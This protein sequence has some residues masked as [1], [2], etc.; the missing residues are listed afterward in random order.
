[1]HHAATKFN[2]TKKVGTTPHS[3]HHSNIKRNTRLEIVSSLVSLLGWIMGFVC[4]FAFGE[5][6]GSP[7][8]SQ[9]SQPATGRLD[10]IFRI[11]YP[12][13]KIKRCRHP[14]GMPSPLYGFSHGLTD[15][16]LACPLPLLRRGRPFESHYPP[17]QKSLRFAEGFRMGWIMG[18]EPTTF[19]ATI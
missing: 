15:M 16:P 9:R 7:R 1:M 17:M 8:S 12:Q 6:R 11:P 13:K 14:Y 5:N 3:G 4:I 2:I 18:F 19:R 10:L